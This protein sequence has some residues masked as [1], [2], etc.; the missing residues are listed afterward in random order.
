MTASCLRAD[1][2]KGRQSLSV[3]DHDE[4]ARGGAEAQRPAGELTFAVLRGVEGRVEQL[5]NVTKVGRHREVSQGGVGERAATRGGGGDAGRSLGVRVWEELAEDGRGLVRFGLLCFVWVLRQVWQVGCP[6]FTN[7]NQVARQVPG[8]LPTQCGFPG[9]N[10]PG[11]LEWQWGPEDTGELHRSFRLEHPI[12][13]LKAVGQAR[14]AYPGAV[15][16]F[17]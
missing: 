3:T 6:A 2:A 10:G 5:S 15:S 7:S 16:S 13:E 1:S 8:N 14:P 12:G 9:P 4:A 17:R 11:A